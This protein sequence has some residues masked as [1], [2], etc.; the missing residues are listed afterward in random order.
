M[1]VLS[2]LEPVFPLLGVP[3]NMQILDPMTVFTPLTV[4]LVALCGLMGI[5][6]GMLISR[7]KTSHTGETTQSDM[8]P[9]LPKAA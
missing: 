7:V 3:P 1:E 6:L 9:T 5:A 4:A 8:T 2:M